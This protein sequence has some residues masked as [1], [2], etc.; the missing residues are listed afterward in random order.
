MKVSLF[1]LLVFSNLVFSQNYV[2]TVYTISTDENIEYG[3]AT[4]FAGTSI[5]LLMDISYPTNDVIP[6]CGRPL[7]LIIHGG[8][9]TAG[10]KDDA[11][12]A[13]MRR[14]FAK[15]GYVAASFNYRLGYFQSHISKNCN[16][17]NWNCLN[18][19]DSS[20]WM[21][22]WY[23]G[24]QDAKGALR[25]LIENSGDYSIDAS[26]VFTFGESAGA[27][28]ALGVAYLDDEN[29]KPEDC[30]VRNNV[31]A[32][33][34][35]YNTP[36]I[37]PVVSSVPIA[38]MDLSRPDLG[39][40]HGDLNPSS[41]PYII[42]GVGSFYG[43]LFMDLFSLKSYVNTPKLYWFH[44][45]NDLIV[46]IGYDELFDG[47]NT[48]SMNTGCVKIQD[49]PMSYGGYGVQGMLDTLSVPAHFIPEMQLEVTN[50]NADC[51]VQV[52]NPAVGG[53][54]L[55]GYWLR[56][57]NMAT[58]FASSIGVNDCA[59]LNIP[60]NNF[61]N[62]SIYP[63]PSKQDVQLSG[64]SF[65]VNVALRNMNGQLLGDFLIESKEQSIDVSSLQSGIYFVE[66]RN[67]VNGSLAVLKVVKE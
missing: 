55:D 65:P 7:A 13:R 10:S 47:F 39:S 61:T 46:P 59:L 45:P 9:F 17:A 19:A 58:F 12:I 25:F 41:L 2:D 36:C 24:V 54:Q 64:C 49:L 35:D 14:D 3:S 21:R 57:T 66:V 43:G 51:V 11:Q 23:R 16:V 60:E 1:S 8:A 50:N 32:P 28:I 15:R 56:T 42:K 67:A 53:H 48:C 38:Q 26:N 62:V 4:N 40:V 30:G 18:L 52:L 6:S 37:Q 44:Q 5:Q 22:A 31:L 20:E 34:A 29:E 63:N 27:F 33:H